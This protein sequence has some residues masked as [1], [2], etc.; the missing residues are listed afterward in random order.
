MAQIHDTPK[1]PTGFGELKLSMMADWQNEK[2]LHCNARYFVSRKKVFEEQL[3]V[4]SEKLL[5]C[6]FCG[7]P[8][9]A[10]LELH[11]LDGDHGNYKSENLVLA[12]S[13]CHRLHHLGWVATENLG[14]LTFI[15]QNAI[16]GKVGEKGKESNLPPKSSGIL[17]MLNLFSFYKITQSLNHDPSRKDKLSDYN[18]G[19]MFAETRVLVG[20]SGMANNYAN[21]LMYERKK[22]L[23][24]KKNQELAA[25][26]EESGESA[27]PQKEQQT[28]Q[29]SKAAMDA[30]GALQ[31]EEVKKEI[32]ALQLEVSQLEETINKVTSKK[33]LEDIS[34][35]IKE[36]L[37]SD[38]RSY[39]ASSLHLLD[40]LEVLEELDAEY[41]KFKSGTDSGEKVG[42]K[43][44]TELFFINQ[45]TSLKSGL[46]AFTIEFNPSIFE[47]W[48][49]ALNYTLE[50]RLKF[51][52]NT[53][54]L[55]AAKG[56]ETKHKE[57]KDAG[58]HVPGLDQI[59]K[60][61]LDN[62]WL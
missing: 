49:P 48:H 4:T 1:L 35:K 30:Y 24:H 58:T 51:Y 54:G 46:G 3:D 27:D 16:G 33:Q 7:F 57:G 18:L 17:E 32:E 50:E 14:K 52:I 45:N 21:Q 9:H 22:A 39:A 43:S 42:D 26:S 25:M 15:P 6:H 61:F 40:I 23:L 38:F 44:P 31:N 56:Y 13:C 2:K 8:D 10:F 62:N 34:N 41:L 47:P 60:R 29:H 5:T 36:D 37:A 19:N 28:E 11:H 55:G 12:C 53:L 59:V 20:S